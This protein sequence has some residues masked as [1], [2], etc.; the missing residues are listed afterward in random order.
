M[1][2]TKKGHVQKAMH[3]LKLNRWL[4]QFLLGLLHVLAQI[5]LQ[6]GRPSAAQADMLWPAVPLQLFST[7]SE[8]ACRLSKALHFKQA[9]CTVHWREGHALINITSSRMTHGKEQAVQ[10]L[11]LLN[12]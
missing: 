5:G 6:P 1:A 4:R 3:N 9:V 11:T 7:S 2:E 10:P 12:K 8:G